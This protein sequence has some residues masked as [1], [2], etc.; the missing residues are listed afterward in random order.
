MAS[1]PKALPPVLRATA[2]GV[3]PQAEMIVE[4]KA[5]ENHS[6]GWRARCISRVGTGLKCK[7]RGELERPRVLRGFNWHNRESGFY[8][9]AVRLQD[10]F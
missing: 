5:K 8:P 3:E 1:V 10:R 4:A 6:P 7:D 2:F 9:E